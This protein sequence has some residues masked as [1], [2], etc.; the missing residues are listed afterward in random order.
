MYYYYKLRGHP[1]SRSNDFERH[2]QIDALPLSSRGHERRCTLA[3]RC[4]SK[5]AP[6]AR[7]RTVPDAVRPFACD[8][9][10]AGEQ[11]ALL[12]VQLNQLAHSTVRV[13]IRL[14]VNDEA[15]AP[16]CWS[17][18]A[19]TGSRPRVFFGSCSLHCGQKVGILNQ[20]A[21]KQEG[22]EEDSN[23]CVR[24]HE[25]LLKRSLLIAV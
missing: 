6:Y 4:R 14:A 7:N 9:K 25:S 13:H 20:N 5:L 3:C 16:P 24:R 1:D 19:I 10:N 2:R 22:R 11:A 12:C 15:T 8:Q 18:P 23:T 21:A 17:E